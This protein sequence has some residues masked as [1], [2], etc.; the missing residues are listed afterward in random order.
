[1][2]IA[3]IAAGWGIVEAAGSTR[4][5]SQFADLRDLSVPALRLIGERTK[6]NT[7]GPPVVLATNFVTAD[8]VPTVGNFRPLWSSHTT[9]AGGVSIAENKRL[10]YCYLYYSGFSDKDLLE[11]LQV[12]SFEVTAAIFGSE[13]A[14]PALA[15]HAA[16]ITAQEI[17]AEAKLYSDFAKGFDA[18]TAS[19]PV[20][21]YIIVPAEGENNF[22]SLDRWYERDAG[23]Q[24][25]L[26][27]VYR[28]TVRR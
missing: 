27:K 7:D 16:P 24:A 8:F 20:L 13:R 1:M 12:N 21:S 10:F 9:S 3:V 15:S 25:G 26:F 4:R 2:Y 28:V 18:A 6:Q 5:N 23:T 11:A 22:T 17:T 19:N 14:L